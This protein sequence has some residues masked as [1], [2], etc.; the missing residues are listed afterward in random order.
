MYVECVKLIK[1]C[2]NLINIIQTMLKHFMDAN[3]NE[4]NFKAEM[5]EFPRSWL[6]KSFNRKKSESPN[7]KRFAQLFKVLKQLLVIMQQHNFLQRISN[8]LHWEFLTMKIAVTEFFIY[9][10]ENLWLKSNPFRNWKGG[11]IFYSNVNISMKASF[12]WA[13]PFCFS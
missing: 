12:W 9:K 5:N 7:H 3:K 11:L 6:N 13:W 8:L 2:L 1:S 10:F 4:R